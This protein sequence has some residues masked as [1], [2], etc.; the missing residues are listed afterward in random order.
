MVLVFFLF[1][2][3]GVVV[4]I[5]GIVSA[6]TCRVSYLNPHGRSLRT[7][8]SSEYFWT[9]LGLAYALWFIFI[10]LAV[11]GY[12]EELGTFESHMPARRLASF[13]LG[14]GA[15]VLALCVRQGTKQRYCTQ[16]I[17]QVVAIFAIAVAAV[18][19]ICRLLA[20]LPR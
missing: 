4:V 16:P 1:L 15:V 18:V 14:I 7:R 13:S 9:G 11:F 17:W 12:E 6:T 20:A 19:P 2:F 8:T 5:T 3:V 10:A